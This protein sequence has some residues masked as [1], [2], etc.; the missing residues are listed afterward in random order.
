[1]RRQIFDGDDARADR[2]VNVVVQ[3]GQ[4]VSDLHDLA[5]EGVGNAPALGSN[6]LAQLRVTQDPIP[7]FSG[8]IQAHAVLLEVL[9]DTHALFVVA[10]ATG[11]APTER[12]FTRMA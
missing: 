5:L 4:A 2:I 6:A 8:E 3:V 1:M 9:D 12:I 10:K 11:Q 7:Y